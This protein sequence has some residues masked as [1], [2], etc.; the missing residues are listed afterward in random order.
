VTIG[1]TAGLLPISISGVGARDAVIEA[2]L[3]AGGCP[4][5]DALAIP[6]IYTALII[7][8]NFSGGIFF[9][10]DSRQKGK[11][12]KELAEKNGQ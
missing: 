7:L 10:I 8:Y 11:R 4:V 1:N 9:I 12:K 6:I 3:S 5:G 2:V